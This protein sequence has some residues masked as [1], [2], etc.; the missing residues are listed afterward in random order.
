VLEHNLIIAN[1]KNLEFLRN[2]EIYI[3]SHKPQRRSEIKP[4]NKNDITLV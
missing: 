4:F 2:S 1:I 3:L